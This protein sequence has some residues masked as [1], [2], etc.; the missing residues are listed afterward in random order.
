[1]WLLKCSECLLT[2][3]YVVTRVFWNGC[4]LPGCYVVMWFL[5]CFCGCRCVAMW[6]SE[7]LP[8]SEWLLC[9]CVVTR[10]F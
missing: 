1:M 6:L 10:V 7:L 4:H 3:C 2:C 8:C 9:Y 5:M